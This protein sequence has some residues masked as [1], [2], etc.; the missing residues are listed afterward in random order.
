MDGFE[1]IKKDF[2]CDPEFDWEPVELL[3]N[4]GDV[5]KGG[6]S[7]DDT[8][9]RVLDQLELM[10]GFVGDTEKERITVIN[11]GGDKAVN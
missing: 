10:E 8:G 3:E 7:G 6:G 9:C 2:E 4:G 5:V 11:M 1:C